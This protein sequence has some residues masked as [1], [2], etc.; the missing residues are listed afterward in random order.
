MLLDQQ[1]NTFLPKL[2]TINAKTDKDCFIN[3]QK[4]KRLTLETRTQ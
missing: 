1:S 2:L 3:R 4:D